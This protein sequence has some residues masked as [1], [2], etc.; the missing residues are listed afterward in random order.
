[1]LQ[2][3]QPVQKDRDEIKRGQ[4]GPDSAG[5]INHAIHRREPLMLQRLHP[6]N[7]RQCQRD[8]KQEDA[9]I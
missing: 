5:E 4:A 7:R 1:M 6:H 9:N 3:A 2:A 8:G